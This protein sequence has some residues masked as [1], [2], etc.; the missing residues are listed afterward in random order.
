MKES[1]TFLKI[2]SMLTY[3]LYCIVWDVGIVA[4][5]AY[6]VFWKDHSGWWFLLA[7][8]IASVG[9]QPHHWRKLWTSEE[10]DKSKEKDEKS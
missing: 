1:N 9:Y 8:S 10:T 3:L 4:G 5:C 2:V 6:L 7:M